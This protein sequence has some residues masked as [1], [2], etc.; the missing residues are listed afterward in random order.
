ME[1]WNGGVLHAARQ[2]SIISIFHSSSICTI[3]IKFILT[4]L[5][6]QEFLYFAGLLIKSLLHKAESI[7]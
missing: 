7:F 5:Q 6:F 4:E 3:F 2:K 1:Y